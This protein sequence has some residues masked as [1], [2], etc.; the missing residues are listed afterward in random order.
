MVLPSITAIQ[1][2]YCRFSKDL[3]LLSLNNY[4]AL[5][6]GESLWRKINHRLQSEMIR[7]R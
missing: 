6:A 3:W 1:K 7:F 2:L 4:G 5:T